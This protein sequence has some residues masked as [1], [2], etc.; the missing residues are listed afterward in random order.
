MICWM[1]FGIGGLKYKKV[2][3]VFD[4]SLGDTC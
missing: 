4:T 1:P 2:F 3:M